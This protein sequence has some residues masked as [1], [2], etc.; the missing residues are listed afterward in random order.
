MVWAVTAGSS[1]ATT[2]A[3]TWSQVFGGGEATADPVTASSLVVVVVLVQ[4]AR[5]VRSNNRQA[6]GVR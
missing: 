4:I 3:A 2:E 5:R 1:L 6:S